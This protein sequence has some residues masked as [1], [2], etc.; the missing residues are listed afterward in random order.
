MKTQLLRTVRLTVLSILTVWGI[1]VAQTPENPL[2]GQRVLIFSKT[3]G[4]R[5]SSIPQGI[6]AVKLMGRKYGFEVDTT[7]NAERF[8]EANLKRYK[9]VVFMSTTGDVLNDRQ[10]ADFERYIQAGG[11]YAGLHAA[12]DTEY[13]WP[14]YGKLVGGYFASHP[15]NPNVQ[16]GTMTVV[17]KNFPATDSL[18]NTFVKK[19]EFYDF[20]QFNP[21]DFAR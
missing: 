19:D 18:P 6:A 11:A 1:S 4:Y 15:G 14:W 17:N 2:K 3:R 5:H 9:V 10:Q 13:D 12:A 7:E 21:F 16:N 8:N 20:K